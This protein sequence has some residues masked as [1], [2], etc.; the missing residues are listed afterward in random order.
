MNNKVAIVILHY[1][2]VEDT[3]ECI[4]SILRSYGSSRIVIVDNDP[5]QS[6]C[7]PS[8]IHANKS[9]EIVRSGGSLGFAAANNLAL[10]ALQI[11][12]EYVLFLN[13]DTVVA[14]DSISKL[15]DYLE[16]ETN[17]GAC[18]PCMPYYAEKNK[19]WA[20]GGKIKKSTYGIAGYAQKQSEKP[21]EVD[22]LPGAAILIRTALFKKVGMFDE[23]FYLGHEEA[24][25]CNAVN[26][27]NYKIVAI[28][29]AVIWHKVG[30]SSRSLV[31]GLVYNSCRN[32][33]SYGAS[34]EG[35]WGQIK[36]TI[37]VLAS[38]L[39]G[40]TKVPLAIRAI[41]DHWRRLPVTAEVISSINKS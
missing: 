16:Q 33:I 24:A 36:G 19:I 38:G 21:H 4:S 3:T 13:N 15:C 30:I 14:P 2:S 12:E 28:P 20:C 6:F 10:R 41:V 29:S 25:L 32:L 8:E 22:Y 5:R 26:R 34:T 18:G 17:C 9:I 39:R 37:I 7:I 11:N 35:I 27:F 1:G 23:R 31:P 40:K